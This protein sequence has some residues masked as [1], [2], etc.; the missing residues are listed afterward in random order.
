MTWQIIG[1][2]MGV[3]LLIWLYAMLT[4]KPYPYDEMM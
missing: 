4:S 2:W 1:L 3:G